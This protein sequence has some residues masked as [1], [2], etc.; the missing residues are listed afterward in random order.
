MV[1]GADLAQIASRMTGKPVGYMSVAAS[2]LKA[3]MA[4]LPNFLQEMLVS[5]E[6]AIAE[7]YLAVPSGAV[8]DLTGREPESVESFLLRNR[9]ALLQ[10]PTARH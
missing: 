6:V 2:T 10:P 3:G 5:A 8:K 1:T 7:G 9:E 4:G